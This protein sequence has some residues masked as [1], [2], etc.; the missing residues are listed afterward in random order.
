MIDHL[1]IDRVTYFNSDNKTP[2]EVHSVPIGANPE[3]YAREWLE[4]EKRTGRPPRSYLI[5][6][7]SGRMRGAMVD[8]TA[9]EAKKAN[10]EKM[11]EPLGTLFSALWQEVAA[12]HFHWKEYVELFGT[13][14]ERIAL[15]IANTIWR[16]RIPAYW[17]SGL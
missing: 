10:I 4:R 14:P 1:R 13:K 16:R 8:R 2:F 3:S 7:D 6:R 5:E 12:L 11:G 17:G 9:E 15:L